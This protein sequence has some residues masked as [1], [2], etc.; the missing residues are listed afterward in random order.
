MKLHR[1]IDHDSQM[2]AIDFQVTRSNVKVTISDTYL[3]LFWHV[4]VSISNPQVV[5]P[6]EAGYEFRKMQILLNL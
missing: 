4:D 1:Y 3:S 5:N 2:T 6:Y